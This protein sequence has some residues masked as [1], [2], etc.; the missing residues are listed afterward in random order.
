[1]H[2]KLT[3]LKCQRIPTKGP[4]SSTLKRHQSG[5]LEHGALGGPALVHAEDVAVGLGHLELEVAL[6]LARLRSPIQIYFN[7]NM[8]PLRHSAGHE[9]AVR[10][11]VGRIFHSARAHM[12]ACVPC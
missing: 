12:G 1:M 9:R 6:V 2:L 8:H 10:G 3:R 4:L 5:A 11:H 7:L